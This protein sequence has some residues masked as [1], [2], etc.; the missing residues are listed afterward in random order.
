MSGRQRD[1][2]IAPGGEERIAANEQRANARLNK[3]S[4]G[5]VD[6]AIGTGILDEHL[7]PQG[8]CRNQNVCRLGRGVWFGRINE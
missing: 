8:A 5:R 3:S 4:E 1:H 6:V 2:L 7:Q